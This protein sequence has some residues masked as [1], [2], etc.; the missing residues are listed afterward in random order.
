[1]SINNWSKNQASREWFYNFL[2][3]LRGFMFFVIFVVILVDYERGM[4]ER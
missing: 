1:M 3:G 4:D 2:R